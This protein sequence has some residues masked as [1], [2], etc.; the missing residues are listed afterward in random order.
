MS[1]RRPSLAEFGCAVPQ[2]RPSRPGLPTET[3]AATSGRGCQVKRR[4]LGTKLI[5]KKDCVYRVILIS[6][7][8]RTLQPVDT[9]T[10]WTLD[11]LGRG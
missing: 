6:A 1:S 9:L 5:K 10:P 7:S 8:L 2:P 11:R 4:L 3:I